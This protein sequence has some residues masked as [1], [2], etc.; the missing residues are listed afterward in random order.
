MKIDTEILFR[1]QEV[2]PGKDLCELTEIV[3]RYYSF[4]NPEFLMKKMFQIGYVYGKR[5][6]RARKKG[7]VKV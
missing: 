3:K 6:E 7:G 4:S 2:I 1:G 5:A